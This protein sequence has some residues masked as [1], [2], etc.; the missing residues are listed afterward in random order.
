MFRVAFLK[1]Q[2]NQTT[3]QIKNKQENKI[4]VSKN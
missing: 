3:K 4:V 2:T 1:E